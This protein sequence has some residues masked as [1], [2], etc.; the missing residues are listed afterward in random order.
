M[1]D[2]EGRKDGGRVFARP[3]KAEKCRLEGVNVF[4]KVFIFPLGHPESAELGPPASAGY[5]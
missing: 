4:T 2:R 3:A 5:F 1:G